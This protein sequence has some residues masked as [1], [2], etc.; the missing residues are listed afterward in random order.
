MGEAAKGPTAVLGAGANIGSQ[1]AW[2][3][4]R[5]ESRLGGTLPGG[6]GWTHAQLK[7]TASGFIQDHVLEHVALLH[8]YSE[9]TEEV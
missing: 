5:A 8:G 3:A 4:C 9:N 1:Q 2:G 6:G 7:H